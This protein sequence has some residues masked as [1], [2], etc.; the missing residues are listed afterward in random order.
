MKN[1]FAVIGFAFLIVVAVSMV[2]GE[3]AALTNE[4]IVRLS[5]AAL[6]TGVEDSVIAAMV[7][8][9]AAATPGTTSRDALFW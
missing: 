8:A 9:G 4:D 7:T 2:S 1:Q 3:D 5:G 6:G